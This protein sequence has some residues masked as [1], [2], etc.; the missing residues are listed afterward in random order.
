MVPRH[1]CIDLEAWLTNAYR[2]PRSSFPPMIATYG[3][4]LPDLGPLKWHQATAGLVTGGV[5]VHHWGGGQN[6]NWIV[7]P[8]PESVRGNLVVVFT[9][10]A[11]CNTL[12]ISKNTNM[13][14]QIFFHGQGGLVLI[15]SG[16]G[17]RSEITAR[18]WS[19]DNLLFWGDKCTSNS[20]SITIAGDR[21]YVALGDDCM[22]A[23]GVDIRTSDE[24]AIMEL[25]G[26]RFL[27]PPASVHVEPHVWLG[28]KCTLLKG[29]HIG[30][31]SVV[32]N[33]SVVTRAVPRFTIAA[34]VPA[35]HVR[36]G[37]SWSR[38]HHPEPGLVDTLRA[39]ESQLVGPAP[40]Q[41]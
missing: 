33:A 28:D 6:K 8:E 1:N 36:T 7:V 10:N 23:R 35:R 29:V 16:M 3:Y 18:L 5:T 17:Q 27:N 15:G 39:S 14:G 41:C 13:H 38:L 26:G 34:G 24:H 2:D 30:Y 40:V 31:G 9:G 11:S 19:E 12:I 25:D 20:V 22:I 21:E 37:V 4:T 32:G